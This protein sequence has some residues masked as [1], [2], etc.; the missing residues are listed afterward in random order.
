MNI[1]GKRWPVKRTELKENSDKERL[2][3]RQPGT[4][5]KPQGTMAA[6]VLLA[7]SV[8]VFSG[9]TFGWYSHLRKTQ[10][11]EVTLNSEGQLV[12][13]DGL[14]IFTYEYQ[15]SQ[16]NQE[17]IKY[18]ISDDKTTITLKSYDSVF[19]RNEQT[20]VY[21]LIPVKGEAV[22]QGGYNLQFEINCGDSTL[23]GDGTDPTKIKPI[24]S[25]V[26]QL[27]YIAVNGQDDININSYND[28][29]SMFHPSD[30]AGQ[31][32]VS[33]PE[34]FVDFTVDKDTHTVTSSTEKGSIIFDKIAGYSSTGVV[35][36]LFELDYSLNL[37]TGF[38]DN[39]ASDDSGRLDQA[40]NLTFT[41][42]T[43]HITVSASRTN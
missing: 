26:A 14:T 25:N 6:V 39:Y 13:V 35:Y 37:V 33:D 4:N 12:N 23:M 24:F 29:R 43:I 27:S 32:V 31:T 42:D 20:P 9:V 15:E 1:F 21:I 30:S 28:A 8:G 7:V 18:G 11:G 38:V 10:A 5:W 19:G 41:Q 16:E 22:Q 40:K 2:Q 36:V 34:C 17:S 3:K